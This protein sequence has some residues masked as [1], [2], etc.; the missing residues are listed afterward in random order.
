MTDTAIDRQ[1]LPERTPQ[2]RGWE[3]GRVELPPLD[4][5]RHMSEALRRWVAQ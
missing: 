3:P 2:N 5:Y 1:G 4:L